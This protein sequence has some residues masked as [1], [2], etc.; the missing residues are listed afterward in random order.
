MLP[1]ESVTLRVMAVPWARLTVH[2]NELPLT[3]LAMVV[4]AAADTWPA[5]MATRLYGPVPPV[6]LR[7]AGWHCWMEGG[8]AIEK[9]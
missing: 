5:G 9:V 1:S 2:E 8:V 7:A 3:M 6:Q 4:K